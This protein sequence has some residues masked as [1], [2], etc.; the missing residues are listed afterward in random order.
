MKSVVVGAGPGGLAVAACL[1]QAGASVAL[2]DRADAVGSAWRGHYDRL[3]LHTPRGRSGLPGL[4]M[5]R[6][7]PRYPSRA[8]V[9][10]YLDAY[11]ERFDLRPRL[12]VG[13]RRVEREGPRWRVVHDH[14]EERAD[15]VVLATGQNGRPHRPS[16]PGMESFDGP[17][18]H[19][20]E[21]RRPADLPGER[22][23]VVGFGNSGGEIALDLAEHGRAVDLAVR[24]PVNLVPR[25]L[26]GV[27]VASL[28]LLRKVLPYRVADAVMAP[29]LRAALGDPERYGLRRRRRG[30]LAQ[31][32]EEGTVP[33]VDIGTLAAIRAGRIT[34]RPGLER[35][36]GRTVRFED[37][38]EAA[39]DAVV[40]ATGYRVDLRPLLRG[41]DGA[42]DAQG[43][44]RV[45]GGPSGAPG[46]YFVGYHA[47]PDGQ[48]YSM[49]RQARAVVKDAMGRRPADAAR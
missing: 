34:V 31:I 49:A 3:H 33:L 48:L 35:F 46:L 24:S 29:V 37:G 28:G 15:V 36:R 9:V 8:Q 41:A 13:V 23:L 4:P 26:L 22:V 38:A 32:R 47:D 12:G 21:Y 18:T 20:A 14:G 1:K 10:E 5:P 19:S 17:V 6:D 40:L 44:P 30:P 42:L 27:P 45:C 7:W 11:A 43:R 16:W 25:D 2:L 39:F